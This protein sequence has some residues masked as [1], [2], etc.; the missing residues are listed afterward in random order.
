MSFRFQNTI[1]LRYTTYVR[2]NV[3]WTMLV[4]GMHAQARAC[5]E[6]ILLLHIRKSWH[7]FYRSAA[8]HRTSELASRVMHGSLLIL[9]LALTVLYVPACVQLFSGHVRAVKRL[10]F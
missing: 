10:A 5:P 4:P 9:L 3:S 7:L 1:D 6:H 2:V 8:V